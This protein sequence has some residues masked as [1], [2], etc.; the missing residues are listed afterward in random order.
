MKQISY[1]KTF[2]IYDMLVK[3]LSQGILSRLFFNVFWNLW[4]GYGMKRDKN[5]FEKC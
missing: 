3:I 1:T 5:D 2:I 4:Y